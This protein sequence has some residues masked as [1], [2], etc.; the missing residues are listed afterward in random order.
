[1]IPFRVV[2]KDKIVHCQ[3]KYVL[4][5][6]DGKHLIMGIRNAD[7]EVKAEEERRKILQDALVAAEH[8]NRAKTTFFNNMSHD[9]RTPLNAIIGF[10]ALAA[11]HIDNQK[12]VADY[13]KKISVSSEHLL[14]LINDVLDMSRIESGMVKIEEKNVHLPDVLHDLK[15][16]I[17]SN[18][19]AK[20]LELFIDTVDVVHEDIICDK[21]RLNQILLNLTSNAVKFTKPGGML[22]I[23][24]IEKANAP[25][26]VRQLCLPG[27]GLRDRHEQGIP[28]AHLRA[29]LPG[30]RPPPSAASRAPAWGWPL[31][32]T[33][34]T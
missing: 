11:A 1:M 2:L 29:P 5:D 19:S 7:A 13:L 3:T 26:R 28:E 32:R 9:I 20:Q 33:L 30:S 17:Q 8:A 34:W 15:T 22:S 16:I 23:R 21:L 25:Q 10:T 14:S 27:E 4:S 6:S 24:V 18:V 12:Q 31:R